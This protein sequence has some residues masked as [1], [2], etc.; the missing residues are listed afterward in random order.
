[1]R[2]ARPHPH[3]EQAEPAR[4]VDL[5]AEVAILPLGELEAIQV[6]SP[7]EAAHQYALFC[8]FAQEGSDIGTVTIKA[9][10][11]IAAPVRKQQHV[12]GAHGSYGGHERREVL[13]PVHERPHLVAA[14]PS[15][16]VIVPAVQLGRG[17]SPLV[18]QKKPIDGSHH[19]VLT[20]RCADLP[21][22]LE[23]TMFERCTLTSRVAAP[24]PVSSSDGGVFQA[25][26]G[27]MPFG[28][29][30]RGS[31]STT[32]AG[33]DDA[34]S[35]GTHAGR[36][37]QDRLAAWAFG[38]PGSD[39]RAPNR[40][41]LERPYEHLGLPGRLRSALEEV[42]PAVAVIVC[43]VGSVL[44]I[45]AVLIGLGLMMVHFGADDRIGHW[46]EHVNEWFAQHRGPI[47]TR[48]SGDFTFLADTDGVAAVTVLVT[49]VLLL[50]RW[51][52]FAWLLAAGLAVELTVF[53]AT[54]YAVER[55]RPYVAHLG[56]TPTTSSWPSGHV[57]ATTVLYGGIAVLIMVA[58]SRRLP[59]LAGW[60]VAVVLITCVAL[61]R[62]YRGDHHPVDTFAGFVLGAA[63]LGAAV[64]VVGV[65]SNR[66][67]TRGRRS[68][69]ATTGSNR[70]AP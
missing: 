39:E 34:L 31:V 41:L 17:V 27:Q 68:A 54:N 30:E 13:G 36:T 19:P 55:P 52:G 16:G 64:F 56:S 61:S 33:D 70:G 32:W 28:T 49:V 62:I 59:R 43:L 2:T 21:I 5:L 14:G 40:A 29:D 23:A 46:D 57:A 67:R 42:H 44:L 24:S 8:R 63:A 3:V 45:A 50:R 69:P 7:D 47:W 53:L 1:M 11:G 48:F 18:G 38:L 65:W 51:G 35:A 25:C 20:H 22:S 10:V 37:R 6:R 12:A 58:T 26:I 15:Q 60:T 66:L 4:G 9:L